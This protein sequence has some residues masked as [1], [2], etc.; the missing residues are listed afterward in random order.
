VA[1]IG[2]HILFEVESIMARINAEPENLKCA[3]DKE[4]DSGIPI[5]LYWTKGYIPFEF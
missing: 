5:P 4:R 1:A 2:H 3:G